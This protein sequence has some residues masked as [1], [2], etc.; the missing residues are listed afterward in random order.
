MQ[1]LK[2]LKLT[3]NQ[4]QGVDIYDVNNTK[5][6]HVSIEDITRGQVRLGFRASDSICIL[7]EELNIN[8]YNR[9]G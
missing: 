9:R 1:E 7:R 6:L 8:D 4:R 3:R 5:I 2:F